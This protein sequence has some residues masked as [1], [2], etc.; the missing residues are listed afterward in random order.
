[1]HM[2]VTSLLNFISGYK[3]FLGIEKFSQRKL[4]EQGSPVEMRI[5]LCVITYYISYF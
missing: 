2:F 5:K 3:M 1:M 4:W